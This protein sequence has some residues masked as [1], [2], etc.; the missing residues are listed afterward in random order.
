[1]TDKGGTLATV[2]MPESATASYSA[3]DQVSSWSWNGGSAQ[4]AGVDNAGNITTDPADGNSYA[5][6]VRNELQTVSG[7]SAAMVY[8]ALGRRENSPYGF[9]GAVSG[10]A[11]SYLYDGSQAIQ[12]S[13]ADGTI[14]NYLRGPGSGEMLMESVA[15]AGAP[16][17][18]L[19][20]ANGS[21]IALVDSASGN[22]VATYTYD[23]FGNV[24]SVTGSGYANGY[25]Y[26]AMENDQW[27]DYG[28]HM[29][30]SPIMG[31]LLSL[32]GRL[33]S[34]GG[35]NSGLAGA[36]TGVMPPGAAGGSNFGDYV[37]QNTEDEA[38]GTAAGFAAGGLVASAFLGSDIGWA[39]GPPGALAGFAI[40]GLI[41]LFQDILGGGPSLPAWQ[42]RELEYVGGSVEAWRLVEGMLQ[43]RVPMQEPSAGVQETPALQE[44]N[45]VSD[46]SP[47]APGIVPV[48]F[49]GYNYCG[50]G[51][52][53]VATQPGTVDDCCRQHDN[54]YGKAGLSF[55]NMGT[56]G[57]GATPA[58]QACDRQLCQCVGAAGVTRPSD[59][60]MKWGIQIYFGCR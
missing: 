29:N 34:R 27:A 50:P 57:A 21:T 36:I 13:G 51:N 4:A 37:A 9:G 33:A 3:I 20:G 49:P 22:V 42:V 11:Q 46:S 30:Y 15:P 53:G 40:G 7:S 58:Q 12:S 16:Q 54:C 17:V 8:D 14:I 24:T 45:P 31:R 48:Q 18:P 60:L 38:A 47:P 41:S 44:S 26:K 32:N 39:G 43:G 1:M 6:D 52:N 25:Q 23:P 59:S 35:H 28:G 55:R 5:W 10:A 19:V 2:G 56:P